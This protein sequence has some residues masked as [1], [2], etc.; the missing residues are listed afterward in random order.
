MYTCPAITTLYKE[1]EYM[2]QYKNER[3]L[4]IIELHMLDQSSKHGL[5]YEDLVNATKTIEHK[6]KGERLK[7]T[8]YS[9]LVKESSE[10]LWHE[11]YFCALF[12]KTYRLEKW[13]HHIPNMDDVAAS[14]R[15]I[16][17][18]TNSTQSTQKIQLLKLS[19]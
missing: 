14:R 12:I 5:N 8:Y 2:E 17:N 6:Y 19:K 3:Q 13:K 4:S 15:A 7:E 1:D 18:L 10:R 16:D 11:A 9:S